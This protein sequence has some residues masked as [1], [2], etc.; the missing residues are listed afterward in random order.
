MKTCIGDAGIPG[1]SNLNELNAM[2]EYNVEVTIPGRKIHVHVH[3]RYHTLCNH[4]VPHDLLCNS[5]TEF[6]H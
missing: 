1:L 3:E 2:F 4:W 5:T 6:P